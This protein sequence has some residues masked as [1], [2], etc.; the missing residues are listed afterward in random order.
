M[1][2][3][4]LYRPRR[5]NPYADPGPPPEPYQPTPEEQARWAAQRVQE[6]AN[7]AEYLRKLAA[8]EIKP[9]QVLTPCRDN[10]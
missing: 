7:R 3:L 6:A 1:T 8:G 4:T 5:R 10:D 2:R 9:H